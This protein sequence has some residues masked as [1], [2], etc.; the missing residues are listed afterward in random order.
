MCGRF[1]GAAVDC[2][3][4]GVASMLHQGREA[5]GADGLLKL[6][7]EFEEGPEEEGR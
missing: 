4:V 1:F 2:V 6:L 7:D 5:G 3:Q